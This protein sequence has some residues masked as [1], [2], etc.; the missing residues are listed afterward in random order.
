M[1]NCET[2]NGEKSIKST[3]SND[4]TQVY[5]REWPFTMLYEMAV[6]TLEMYRYFYQLNRVERLIAK[7]L[8]LNVIID[9]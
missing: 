4:I 1:F 2:I 9:Y 5:E 6:N 7:L 3:D 8:L